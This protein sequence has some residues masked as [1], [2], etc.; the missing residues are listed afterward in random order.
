MTERTAPGWRQLG[1][2]VLLVLAITTAGCSAGFA[3]WLQDLAAPQVAFLGSGDQLSLLVTD[4]PARLLLATGDE[5]I[6]FE[7]ALAKFRP[8]F[9]RRIDVLLVTGQESS[10]LVP[11]AA[12][13]GGHARLALSLGSIPAS[14]GFETLASLPSFA[15]PRR[16]RLG[17]SV[18]VTVETAY[19]FAAD[20]AESPPAWRATIERGESRVVVLSDGEAAALF[21]PGPPASVLAVSS[22]NPETAWSH[23]PAVAFVANSRAISGPEMRSAFAESRHPPAWGFL[24]APGEALRMHFV[25]GGVA[26][27]FDRAQDLAGT[28]AGDSSGVEQPGAQS[29]VRRPARPW[30]SGTRP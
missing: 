14:A 9:A 13:R 10:L 27:P 17:P 3:I 26:L 18:T 22:G 2:S 19:P 16:I 12:Q 15:A 20:P 23:H 7:N 8:L 4:G 30:P 21:P 1:F 25:D 24:V 6:Q 29:R 11:H 28:P 5:P